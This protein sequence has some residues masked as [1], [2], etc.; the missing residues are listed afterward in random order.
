MATYSGIPRSKN[1]KY[2]GY[3]VK[4]GDAAVEGRGMEL[5]DNTT[6]DRVEVTADTTADTGMCAGIVVE[7]VTA[8]ESALSGGTRTSLQVSGVAK[9]ICQAA[10]S[11]LGALISFGDTAGRFKTCG[12]TADTRYMTHGRCL[13]LP[14]TAGDA[15][16][17]ML[18]LNVP[19]TMEPAG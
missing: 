15:C 19:D 14:D 13:G 2:I 16:S 18:N 3:R 8:V 1:G 6:D 9:F 4:S 10:I 7:P 11:T 5:Y 17:V 12:N